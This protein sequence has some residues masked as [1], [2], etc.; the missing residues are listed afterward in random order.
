[1][2][3]RPVFLIPAFIALFTMGCT[4]DPSNSSGY[5][6]GSGD[7]YDLKINFTYS[8]SEFDGAP[9]C[10]LAAAVD[11][12]SDITNNS[13]LDYYIGF[14]TTSGFYTI[15]LITFDTCYAVI[16]L[17]E[18]DDAQIDTGE[19]YEIYENQSAP[20]SATAIDLESTTEI[21]MNFDDTFTWP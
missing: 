10:V 3:L 5:G 8:G 7:T 13:D 15:P 4:N 20:A 16:F 1:M 14:S 21:T 6:S 9:E 18:D 17:D 12:K 11:S 19:S 2:R